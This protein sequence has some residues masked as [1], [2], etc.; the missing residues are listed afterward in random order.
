[1]DNQNPWVVESIEA[2]SFYCCPECDFQSKDEDYF[3]RHAMESHKH[4]KEFFIRSKPENNPNKDSIKVETAPGYQDENE[5]GIVNVSEVPQ[6]MFT[7]EKIKCRKKSFDCK[8]CVNKAF[9]TEFSLKRHN[10]TFHDE[11]QS[12]K[13]TEVYPEVKYSRPTSENSTDTDSLE[14]ETEPESQDENEDGMDNFIASETRV[15]EESRSAVRLSEYME[16]KLI[17]GPDHEI[18]DD[19]E[20][21]DYFEENLKTFDKQEAEY[22]VKELK[23][24]DGENNE[25]ITDAETSDEENFDGIDIEMESYDEH[26]VEKTKTF[27][28]EIFEK[29]DQESENNVRELKTFDGVN[30]KNITDAETS[31]NETFDGMDEELESYDNHVEKTLTFNDE[32]SEN[33][34]TLVKKYFPDTDEVEDLDEIENQKIQENSLL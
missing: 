15:K 29:D 11:K 21:A 9:T 20:T 33:V 8:I 32:N 22:N 17:K 30:Y 31:D 10:K 2:F 24:F 27:N 23:T 18:F 26:D 6:K 13:K 4:S 3:K 19:N 25:N 14:V 12:I 7:A 28:E 34:K 1:M 16:Q 5:E